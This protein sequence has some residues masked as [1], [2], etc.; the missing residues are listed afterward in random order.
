MTRFQGLFKTSLPLLWL[1]ISVLLISGFVST[2]FAQEPTDASD[3]RIIKNKGGQKHI[4]RIIRKAE[5]GMAAKQIQLGHIYYSGSVKHGIEPNH[6]EA[7]KWFE[8]A[9]EKGKA[10]AQFQTALMYMKGYGTEVDDQKAFV[11]LEK[12]AYKGHGSSELL[13]GMLRLAED[14]ESGI[15]WLKKS[16]KHGSKHANFVLGLLHLEGKYGMK[17][18]GKKAMKLFRKAADKESK[19]AQVY[20]GVAYYAGMD[21]VKKDVSKSF[22]WFKKAAENGSLTAQTTLGIYYLQGWGVSQDVTAGFKWMKIGAEHGCLEVQWVLGSLY[23][24]GK[25]V[26]KDLIEAY[27]WYT[28][29]IKNGLDDAREQRDALKIKLSKKQINK[30]KVRA[31]KYLANI[32]SAFTIDQLLGEAPQNMAQELFA[33]VVQEEFTSPYA[34]NYDD[35]EPEK[36]YGEDEEDIQEEVTDNVEPSPVPLPKPSHDSRYEIVDVKYIATDLSNGMTALSYQL[37]IKS[38]CNTPI[39]LFGEVAW[40]DNEGFNLYHQHF[41]GVKIDPGQSVVKTGTAKVPISIGGHITACDATAFV[42]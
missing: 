3:K 6:I 41:Y 32:E 19:Q 1:I 35:S 15:K 16:A 2:T 22:K 31:E 18:D 7:L 11:W 24:K 38:T 10:E 30:A 12:A 23:E 39:N 25:G 21:G 28:V 37:T 20:L 17:Q 29:A 13:Y 9:A 5:K 33:E 14:S 26:K 27:A 40:F 8:R 34:I 42:Q 36:I 4:S